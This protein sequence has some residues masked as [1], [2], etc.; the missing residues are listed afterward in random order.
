[1]IL[2]IETDADFPTKGFCLCC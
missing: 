2:T 1:M